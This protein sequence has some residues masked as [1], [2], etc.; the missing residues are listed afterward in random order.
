MPLRSYCA[1]HDHSELIHD[2]ALGKT[3]T[4]FCSTYGLSL[5]LLLCNVVWAVE[6]NMSLLSLG[7][8]SI[9]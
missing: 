7:L 2:A 9:F 6:R 5:S 8:E 3:V 4:L 1:V